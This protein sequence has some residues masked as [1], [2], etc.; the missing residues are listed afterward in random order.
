MFG[1]EPNFILKKNLNYINRITIRGIENNIQGT[2]GNIDHRE[3]TDIVNN[4]V[5]QAGKAANCYIIAK[6]GEYTIP[7]YKGAY[8]NLNGATLCMSGKN[9][10]GQQ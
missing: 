2:E 8:N 7:A 10:S 9:F 1:I 3:S 6:P 4:P 5:A